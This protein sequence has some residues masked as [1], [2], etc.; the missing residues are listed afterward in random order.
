MPTGIFERTKQHKA[1]I[2]KALLGRKLSLKHRQNMSKGRK[3]IPRPD[4]KKK[5]DREKLEGLYIDERLTMKQCA[6]VFNCSVMPIKDR[7][8]EFAIS[9]RSLSEASTGKKLTKK[10]KLKL[11]RVLKGERAYWFGKHLTKK[12]REKLSTAI[13]GKFAGKNNPM[14]GVRGKDAPNWKNGLSREPYPLEWR[15]TL[16][17]SI[18]Q[19]DN[20]ICQKCHMPQRELLRKLSIHHIDY[21]KEN[22]DPENLISLCNAC[23][24]EVNFNREYWMNYFRTILDRYKKVEV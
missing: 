17:E 12:T 16:R 8:K 2:S 9:I 22:L 4:R 11:S 20:Y 24:C 5:I 18:R 21:I 15:E 3:G 13:K 10:H 14:Y 6:K 7:L 19:R 23:N 1:R